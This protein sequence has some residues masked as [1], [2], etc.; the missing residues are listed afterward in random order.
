M[1][2]DHEFTQQPMIH[3]HE[4]LNEA[5]ILTEPIDISAELK[6]VTIIQSIQT[7]EHHETDTAGDG[8]TKNSMQ[9]LDD[10]NFAEP[11]VAI[12]QNIQAAEQHGMD[13]EG[14]NGVTKNSTQTLNNDK[15]NAEK[16]EPETLLDLVLN[17]N[18]T[19]NEANTTEDEDDAAAALL[20]LSKLDILPK[21]DGELPVGV[22]PVD[23]APVPIALDNQDV[24]NAIENFK[25]NNGETGTPS[26]NDIPK[27]P[28]DVKQD[29]NEKENKNTD[30]KGQYRTPT[31]S[32]I[33]FT[34]FPCQR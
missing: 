18:I 27:I 34:N 3:E 12:T 13:T 30:K 2:L 17:E 11:G 21:E 8:V 29:K 14:V 19:I 5:L 32:R 15:R 25:Q 6:G 1:E 31:C 16:N 26:N 24:L 4:L 9:T 20:Q 10:D 7:A 22:L 33:V 23:A 28:D